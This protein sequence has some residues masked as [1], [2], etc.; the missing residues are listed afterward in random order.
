MTKGLPLGNSA[1]GEVAIFC[2]EK[3]EHR[4]PRRKESSP[5]DVFKDGVR[6]RLAGG[7]SMRRA[8]LFALL[9][10]A[11]PGT[12][13]ADN[14]EFNS[15]TFVSGTIT[16]FSNPF[17]VRVVGTSNTIT[18]DIPK[19]SCNAS[20]TECFFTSATVTVV[21]PKG[22]TIF[23]DGVEPGGLKIGTGTMTTA[24]YLLPDSFGKGG[25]TEFNVNF[26]GDALLAGTAEVQ[27]VPDPSALE[28]LL[29]GTG[30]LGLA[31]MARRKLQ[32]GT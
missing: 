4:H 12:A 17:S 25:Y 8:I 19:L 31:G 5:T 10:F 2:G 6:N 29:L 24:L 14:I 20:D 16:S 30:L 32:L 11:L 26:T 22:D 3:T 9:A 18:L 23:M 21:N 27:P 7:V 15:G 13:L 28:G 1:A